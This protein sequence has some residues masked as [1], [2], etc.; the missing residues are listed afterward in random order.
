MYIPPLPLYDVTSW[1]P[2]VALSGK[3]LNHAELQYPMMKAIIDGHH[4]DDEIDTK[5]L[6]DSTFFSLTHMGSGSSF[7][8]DKIDDQHFS[9]LV[10]SVLPV[11]SIIWFKGTD[12]EIPTGWKICNGQTGTSDY[13]DRFIIG[14]GGA[15]AVGWTGGPA[16]YNGTF[17]PTGSVTVGAH[18]LTTAELPVH[19]HTF[20]E[21]SQTTNNNQGDT[22]GGY[23]CYTTGSA[24]IN[25]QNE[26]GGGSHGHPGSTEDFEYR[27]ISNL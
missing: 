27:C 18:T 8:A 12:A 17:T 15:Y 11:G 5:A 4:H 21:Y 26:G 1:V 2:G 9:D 7:D 22:P 14:A 20:T 13:R 3:N 25:N 16:T 10:A 6:A 23:T 19:Y 24:S